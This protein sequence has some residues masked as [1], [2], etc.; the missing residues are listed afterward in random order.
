MLFSWV[1]L[2]GHIAHPIVSLKRCFSADAPIFHLH[3]N[4]GF[5]AKNYHTFEFSFLTRLRHIIFINLE[6]YI[7]YKKK[8]DYV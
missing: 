8:R 5:I 3:H 1:L 7:N 6:R 2:R 4:N